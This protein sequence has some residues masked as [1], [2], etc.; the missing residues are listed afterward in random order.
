MKKNVVSVLTVMLLVAI[1]LFLTACGNEPKPVVTE[2]FTVVFDVNAGSAV[3]QNE[4][5]PIRVDSG[6]PV[7][8]PSPDPIR[9]G[10]DFLG[11][12]DNAEGTGQSYDFTKPITKNNF[13]LYAKWSITVIY[14][15]VTF[16]FMD[17]RSDVLVQVPFG[18]K[19]TEPEQPN[20][21]GYRFDGWFMDNEMSS[22]YNFDSDVEDVF[23]LYAKWIKV[24]TITFDFNYDDAPA[25]VIQIV[26]ANQEAS[27]PT[28]PTRENF[29]FAGWFMDSN[30]TT[31]YL[32]D[33]VSDD[34][35]LY[36]KWLDNTSSNTFKVEFIYNYTGAPANV[37]QN[38]IEGGVASQLN[39]TREN[40][41][42][43]G[44]YL[45][46]ETFNQ[47]FYLTT[48]ITT[49][50]VLYAKWVKVYQISINY[51]YSGAINPQPVLVNE[52]EAIAL[53]Q[54]PSRI[55]F[56]FTGWSHQTDGLIGFNF[57]AGIHENTTVYAQWSKV[58]V[59]EAEHLDF[60]NFY[61]WGF[62][63]NATGTDAIVADPTGVSQA[64][65]GHFVTYLYGKDITLT[66]EIYSD[67]A[68]DNVV[69]T[70]RL[71]G[72]VKDFFIQ[73]HKTPG[74]LEQEPVYTVKVNNLSIQ[75]SK[76]YFTNVPS[77]SDNTLLPFQDF[78]ISI[79]INLVKGKNTIQLITD[80]ELLMGGTMGA[81]APMIDC[82]KLTTYAILSWTPKLD[83]Y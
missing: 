77:Q 75:Y 52:G 57:S 19:V 21:D 65:N 47:R 54:N 33:A 25:Q 67:R 36:A 68:V 79:N 35:T 48:P 11:W 1:S 81:T 76:I 69:L 72:E 23:T 9:N 66:F 8:K 45:D 83:N 28:L 16:Q 6:K 27:E 64:S 7:S 41:R 82:L 20:R 58:N 4:P 59:F 51:N 42:F 32:F 40:Y 26:D 74:V 31:P 39:T 38:V 22:S 2:K 24:Y 29:T 60:S 43:L 49:E 46:N 70:L 14:K 5:S 37:I 80:N 12:F 53:P 73:S 34:I 3:V 55:G 13:T 17:G 50:L 18:Q 61:G 10:Y 15:T 71:S 62:S 78:V 44:W 56:T 30:F 63:G